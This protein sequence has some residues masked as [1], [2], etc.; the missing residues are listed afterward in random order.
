MH[1]VFQKRHS[2]RSFQDKDI[3]PEDLKEI[4][5]AID[6]APSARNLKA[7]EIVIVK[8]KETKQKLAEASNGQ[9]FVAEAAV[10]LVFFSFSPERYGADKKEL[11]T[12]QDATIATSFAWIQAVLLGIAGCWVGGFNEDEVRKVLGKGEDVKPVAIL[13]LGYAV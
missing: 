6:S 3:S 12:I 4:L 8:D 5:D 11:Y 7:R 2:T 13:P 9:Q 10:V 1:E